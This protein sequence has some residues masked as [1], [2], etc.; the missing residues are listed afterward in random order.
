MTVDK[1]LVK[2]VH[3]V[4]GYVILKRQLFRLVNRR[5]LNFIFCFKAAK[6][7]YLQLLF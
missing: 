4:G 7:K 2:M 5:D 3:E 1:K 6:M